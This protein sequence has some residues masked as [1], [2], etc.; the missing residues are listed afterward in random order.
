MF[1]F[2]PV[3]EKKKLRYREVQHPLLGTRTRTWPEVGRQQKLP[4]TEN[5]RWQEPGRDRG[6]QQSSRLPGLSPL[7]ERC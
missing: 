7:E 2:D 4:F 1:P 5:G 3:L 6:P